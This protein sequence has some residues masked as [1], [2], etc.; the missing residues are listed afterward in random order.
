MKAGCWWAATGRRS[1]AK[2]LGKDDARRIAVNITTLLG[3]SL[4]NPGP[5]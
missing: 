1:A 3:P 2:L 5:F 4:Q